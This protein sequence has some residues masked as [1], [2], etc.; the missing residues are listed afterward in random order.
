MIDDKLLKYGTDRER[1]YLLA[2]N[3]HGSNR[4]AA[5]ALG[6]TRRSVDKS[7]VRLK[8]RAARSGYSPDH[9]LIREAAPGFILDKHSD[10]VNEETGELTRRWYKYSADKEKQWD[11]MNAA[12]EAL[13]KA[14]PKAKPT[15]APKST[16]SSLCNLYTL[17]DCHIGEYAAKCVGGDDWNLELAE[18]TLVDVFGAMIEGAPKS[19]H[20]VINQLG[21][22]LHWDGLKNVTP[23]SQHV[24]HSAGLINELIDVAISVIRQLVAIAAKRHGTIKLIMAEGNHDPH[25]SAWMRKAFAMQYE[26]EP[27]VTVD[28]TEV[29]FYAHRHG[30]VM[31][32]FHHGHK[33]PIRSMPGMFADLYS[34]MWGA[35]KHREGHCGHYHQE[36][37]HTLPGMVVH[38]HTTLAATGDYAGRLGMKTRRRARCITY[39]EH[40]GRVGSNDQSPEML[41]GAA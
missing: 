30:D 27:R 40:F 18:R 4:R 1:E 19:E 31:L 29:P 24:L 37:T 22:F 32:G 13:S 17:T 26:N 14:I 15:P 8:T 6:V 36:E 38:R 11:A 7:I 23:Q 34:E 3:K 35:T 9:S 41:K 28:T 33:V 20:C 10:Y 39:H 21:D 25:G 5:E 12:A 16:L 2:V